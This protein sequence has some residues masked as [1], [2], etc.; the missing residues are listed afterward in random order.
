MAWVKWTEVQGKKGLFR[1]NEDVVVDKESMDK[2][3]M[4]ISGKSKSTSVMCSKSSIVIRGQSTRTKN[5]KH[6]E[7]ESKVS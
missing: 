2:A 6:R 1:L 5:K 4:R 3:A 7:Q